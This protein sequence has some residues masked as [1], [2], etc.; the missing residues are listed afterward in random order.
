M[1]SPRSI[2]APPKVAVLL[3]TY[4]GERWIHDQV[5]SILAQADVA[6][7]IFWADDGS[8]DRTVEIMTELAARHQRIYRVVGDPMGSAARNFARILATI[9]ILPFDF[10]AFS[11]QDDIWLPHKLRRAVD[12][13]NQGS[14]DCYASDLITLHADGARARVHKSQPQRK[15]DFLFEPASAA[16]TI[17][18]CGTAA[19]RI[20]EI[21]GTRYLSWSGRESFE[22]VLY[23]STRSRSMPWIIDTV[24]GILY[25]QHENNV[26]G[27]NA[28]W[29]AAARR[30]AMMRSG[31]FREHLTLIAPYCEPSEM[32]AQIQERMNGRG[33]GNRL[34][35]MLRAGQFRRR[36][37]DVWTLRV[38]FLLGWT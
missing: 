10:I 9:D 6:V 2:A 19:R 20:R 31:W 33:L 14:A 35:L 23:A 28:G 22:W 25:R 30:I 18:L 21:I 4:N 8:T 38:A 29:A 3:A 16:C 36:L 13:L 37:R 1:T 32:I 17:V 7:S 5:G 26:F 11:D 12:R 27:A 34:W 24:P 15:F